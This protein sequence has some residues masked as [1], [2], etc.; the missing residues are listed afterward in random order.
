MHRK[1]NSDIADTR[2]LLNTSS[3]T[4]NDLK[5]QLKGLTE[6]KKEAGKSP[7]N[8]QAGANKFNIP[9]PKIQGAQTSAT[10]GIASDSESTPTAN[11]KDIE[12]QQIAPI[13]NI[14][15]HGAS[16]SEPTRTPIYDDKVIETE[17]IT[18]SPSHFDVQGDSVTIETASKSTPM[19]PTSESE[20]NLAA[21]SEMQEIARFKTFNV[22][23]QPVVN[24][25]TPIHL[26]VS[27][28]EPPV[29]NHALAQ[30]TINNDSEEA[31]LMNTSHW[32]PGLDL[33]PLDLELLKQHSKTTPFQNLLLQRW[34]PTCF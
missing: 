8:S 5:I 14:Q 27:M 15:G 25:T 18:L 11:N 10:I 34:Q 6:K 33:P 13:V 12:M 22:P 4:T 21:D 30:E 32:H 26:Q 24:Y 16:E 23:L 3:Q 29:P 9:I 2:S 20:D 17:E 31:G 19:G 1:L 28:F 7:R